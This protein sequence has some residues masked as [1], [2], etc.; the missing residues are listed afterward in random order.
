VEDEMSNSE[1]TR[2][3]SG[4][5]NAWQS[6][7]DV[8]LAKGSGVA[9]A[10]PTCRRVDRVFGRVGA[11]VQP[12]LRVPAISVAYVRDLLRDT[13]DFQPTVICQ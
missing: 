6:A 12:P 9:V 2:S 1:S 8:R 13:I 11:R 7:A 10:V 4:A 5:L 3:L